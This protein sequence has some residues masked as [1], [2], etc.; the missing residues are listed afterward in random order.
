MWALG[1]TGS[2]SG[3]E[4]YTGTVLQG[5]RPGRSGGGGCPRALSAGRGRSCPR[6]PSRRGFRAPRR[7]VLHGRIRPLTEEAVVDALRRWPRRS[8]WRTTG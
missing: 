7:L 1:G 4:L 5:A 6:L 3:V 8:S 2:A